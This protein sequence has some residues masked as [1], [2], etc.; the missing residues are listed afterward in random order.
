MKGAVEFQDL[1]AFY[2]MVDDDL[3]RPREQWWMSLRPIAQAMAHEPQ[4]AHEAHMR[5]EAET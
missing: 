3:Q 4:E 5:E 2:D 1:D